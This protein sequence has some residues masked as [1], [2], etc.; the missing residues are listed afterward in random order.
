M[1][2]VDGKRMLKS[3]YLRGTDESNYLEHSG[4]TMSWLDKLKIKNNESKLDKT[5]VTEDD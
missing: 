3:D 4:T 1:I 2:T 5:A